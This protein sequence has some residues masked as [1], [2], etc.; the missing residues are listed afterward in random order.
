MEKRGK[1]RRDV[2]VAGVAP[3]EKSGPARKEKSVCRQ[4]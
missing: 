4:I 1:K 2:S 3:A